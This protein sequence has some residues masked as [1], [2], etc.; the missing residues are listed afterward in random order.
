MHGYSA[1]EFA[2]MKQ[3]TSCALE[4]TPPDDSN[5]LAHPPYRLASGVSKPG[6]A[7]QPLGFRTLPMSARGVDGTRHYDSHNLYG[8]GQA[9]ATR[10]ALVHITRKRPFVLTRCAASGSAC[11]AH[12]ALMHA[13]M[14]ACT[15]ARAD[16]FNTCRCGTPSP[17]RSSTFAGSG[18]HA[19][20]WSGDNASTWPQ[21]RASVAALLTA[22]IW[23]MPLSGSDIC[24]FMRNAT[25]EL[26]AR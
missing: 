2:V 4:C 13:C 15:R 10:D 19:A 21:L 6:D 7:P 18:R 12:S 14:H 3:L 24:G 5:T 11:S 16:S 25:E 23:G 22:N 26:C 20:H 17:M 1:H 9:A 8:M